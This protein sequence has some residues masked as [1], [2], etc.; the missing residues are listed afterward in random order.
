MNNQKPFVAWITILMII[1][2]I[3]GVFLGIQEEISK[4]NEKS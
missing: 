1:S 2:A 3:A 4:K